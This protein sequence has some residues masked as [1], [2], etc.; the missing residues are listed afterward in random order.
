MCDYINYLRQIS[1][2]F[3]KLNLGE[4]SQNRSGATKQEYF[5]EE[6][7]S[8]IENDYGPTRPETKTKYEIKIYLHLT[9]NRINSSKYPSKEERGVSHF[10]PVLQGGWIKEGRTL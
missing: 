10:I 8:K 1:Q 3:Y 7:A 4:T 6:F 2:T 5:V 9:G